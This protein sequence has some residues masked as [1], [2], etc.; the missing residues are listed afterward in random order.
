MPSQSIAYSEQQ[1][2][3]HQG[4]RNGLS[5]LPCTS[6]LR[7]VIHKG[8]VLI[9]ASVNHHSTVHYFVRVA[10]AGLR[11][12]VNVCFPAVFRVWTRPPIRGLKG[13]RST[14]LSDLIV[15]TATAKAS[16]KPKSSQRTVKWAAG[17]V[18][19]GSTAPSFCVKASSNPGDILQPNDT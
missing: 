1:A 16:D 10:S 2:Q 17:G 19:T 14:M 4:V 3:M 11:S 13:P 5:C 9:W 15:V 18:C 7:P 12:C 6:L 8:T